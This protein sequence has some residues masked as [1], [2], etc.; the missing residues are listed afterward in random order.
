MRG[1]VENRSILDG[2][3][4]HSKHGHRDHRGMG[5]PKEDRWRARMIVEPVERRKT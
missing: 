4:Q 2:K 1:E 5:Q 3:T